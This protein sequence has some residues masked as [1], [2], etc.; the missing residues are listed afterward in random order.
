MRASSHQPDARVFKSK[1]TVHHCKF[2][3]DIDCS[4]SFVKNLHFWPL[5]DDKKLGLAIRLIRTPN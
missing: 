2:E 4:L 1:V 5:S 3:A